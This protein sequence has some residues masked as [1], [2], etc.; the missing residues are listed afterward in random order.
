MNVIMRAA[1][2]VGE[3]YLWSAMSNMQFIPGHLV[4]GSNNR[5][6]IVDEYHI[7]LTFKPRNKYFEVAIG[8]FVSTLDVCFHIKA[9]YDFLVL[10]ILPK[11]A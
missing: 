1:Y 9:S 10:V 11:K 6:R 8:A 2:W 5:P 3:G 4:L 7:L